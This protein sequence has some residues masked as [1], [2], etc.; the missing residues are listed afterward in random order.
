[1][2]LKRRTPKPL[3]GVNCGK[4]GAIF[5]DRGPAQQV[6]RSVRLSATPTA[7]AELLPHATVWSVPRSASYKQSSLWGSA[8]RLHLQEEQ[9]PRTRKPA[10]PGI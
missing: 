1:M 4:R 5:V 10:T 3:E 2:A 7:R 8:H 6:E 9:D